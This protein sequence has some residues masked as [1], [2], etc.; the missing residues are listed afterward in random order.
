LFPPAVIP[1]PCIPTLSGRNPVYPPSYIS[2]PF[3]PPFPFVFCTCRLSIFNCFLFPFLMRWIRCPH[4]L[5]FDTKKP[6]PKITPFPTTGDFTE[7]TLSLLGR[8]S[9]H[10]PRISFIL[11]P[12]LARFILGEGVEDFVLLCLSFFYLTV[13]YRTPSSLPPTSLWAIQLSFRLS[14]LQS[15]LLLL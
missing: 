8:A 1:F 3:L 13:S 14:P 11:D 12:T 2:F 6:G 15:K 4:P 7:E 5:F 10:L 9:F